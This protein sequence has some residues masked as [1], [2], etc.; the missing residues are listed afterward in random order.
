MK[1]LLLALI[2]TLALPI[3]AAEPLR[4]FIRAGEKTHRPGAHEHERFLTDWTKMLKERGASVDGA[5]TFPTEAQLKKADVMVFYA[6]N[7]GTMNA[8]ERILLERFRKRGG[9]LVFIHD[10]VCGNDAHW[11]KGF[12]GGA[13]EH[14]HSKY[15]M[16][17]F[18]LDFTK[19][20]HPITK[21]A[22]NFR[23]D[24]ELYY[25][26][27][28][29]PKI[30]VLAC[31]NHKNAPLSPQLWS[32]ENGKSRTFTSIP[33]HWYPSFSI[34]QFRAILLR[35]IAWTG[36]RKVDLLTTPEEV[37][38]LKNPKDGPKFDHSKWKP[39]K[40]K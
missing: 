1:F 27:H 28:F 6:Q 36:H 18:D 16:G 13:W 24:D 4:V 25:K 9:G 33:G 38:A 30:N 35:G 11:F 26:L 19:S 5:L 34:P 3:S 29:D 17:F 2:T 8:N 15:S 32:L 20:E 7:A 23:M 22:G 12:T 40:N 10:A 14:K 31:T 39:V 21:G 37:A